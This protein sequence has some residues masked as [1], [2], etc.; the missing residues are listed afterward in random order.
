MSE[1]LTSTLHRWMRLVMRHSMRDLM[2]YAREKNFSMAQINAL[3][4]I[5]Y[6]GVCDVSSL[7][8]EMGV[9]SAAASQLL[10]RLVQQGLVERTEDPQDRR[11]KRIALTAAGQEIV[12]ESI[13]ARQ[14][15]MADLADLLTPE[16]KEQV[17]AAL[18]I[19]IKRT[20][21]IETLPN[22]ERESQS[23]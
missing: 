12:Q 9:T 4:R 23:V 15:W 22:G 20:A 11:T 6:R 7:S 5:Y 19:L 17:S 13:R 10:E 3:F 18:E 1:P 8:E 16:E 2:L 21:E 14:N